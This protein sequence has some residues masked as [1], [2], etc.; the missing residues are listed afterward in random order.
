MYYILAILFSN[1]FVLILK[2]SGCDETVSIIIGIICGV[3]V[4]FFIDEIRQSNK[5]DN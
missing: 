4:S 3:G 5:K 1:I 2:L